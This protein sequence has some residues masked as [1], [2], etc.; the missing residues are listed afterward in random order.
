MNDQLKN[1]TR[2]QVDVLELNS[3]ILIGFISGFISSEVISSLFLDA[4]KESVD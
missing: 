1:Y 4:T 3:L 2:T